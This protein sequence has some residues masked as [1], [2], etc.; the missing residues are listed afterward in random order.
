MKG[1]VSNYIIKLTVTSEH[2][3]SAA[4]RLDLVSSLTAGTHPRSCWHATRLVVRLFFR[5]LLLLLRIQLLV[6]RI[7]LQLLLRWKARRGALLLRLLAAARARMHF[8][9][10]VNMLRVARRPTAVVR[11]RVVPVQL[12]LE[13]VNE[14]LLVGRLHGT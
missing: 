2:H 4:F 9:L 1:C 7:L 10:R 11:L 8:V 5:R 13:L 6:V 3:H 12:V 14:I